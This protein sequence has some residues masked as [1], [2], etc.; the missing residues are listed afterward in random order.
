MKTNA[1]PC[2][3]K[4]MTTG[5]A[6]LL[7]GGCATGPD[8]VESA[9]VQAEIERTR[10]RMAQERREAREEQLDQ[11]VKALPDWVVEP[12]GAGANA[13]YGVGTA[14]SRDMSA[15]M[16]KARLKADFEL[17][18]Q[19]RQQLSGLSKDY[20]ADNRADAGVDARFEQA[21]ERLVSSVRMGGQELV[22]QDVR[23]VDGDFQAAVLMELN[24]DRMEQI[25][26]KHRRRTG[27]AAMES[28]FA[29]LRSRVQAVQKSQSE[30]GDSG[31]TVPNEQTTN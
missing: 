19:I 5:A 26:A 24:F 31:S 30:R 11:R 10:D 21:V 20:T 15:A 2:A 3:L 14:R 1:K 18:Q 27:M 29:D 7:L 23:V 13:L 12:P 4:L 16:D 28:A 25:L 9:R 17:A 8:P 22:E 6:A